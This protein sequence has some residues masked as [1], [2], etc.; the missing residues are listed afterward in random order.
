MNSSNIEYM[1]EFLFKYSDEELDNLELQ[2]TSEE[3][4]TFK[5]I[6]ELEQQ[7]KDNNNKSFM[8]DLLEAAK[9]G[10]MQYL[11]SMTD[12][13]DTFMKQKR[14]DDT[15]RWDDVKIAPIN[16]SANKEE[17][18]AFKPRTMG[19]ANESALK[20]NPN[21]TDGMSESG[22]KIFKRYE[23]AY[24]QRT[25]SLTQLS[26][27]DSTIERSN[28]KVNFETLSGLRGYRIGPVVAMPSAQQ[29]K[30]GYEAYVKDNPGGKSASYW[31]YDQ[32]MK[33][34]DSRLAQ[35]L[36]FKTA[37]EAEK[38]RKEN[39]L[40]VH[41]GPDGMFMVPSDVHS[42]AR[43]NGYRSMMTEFIKGEITESEMN[44]YIRDEKIAYVSHE[45]KERGIRMVKGIGM[46]AIKDVLKCGVVVICEETYLEFKG[47]SDDKFVDRMLRILKKSWEHVKNKC[48]E[49]IKNLLANIKGS[50]L[51]EILTAINDFFLGTFKNIFKIVRQMWSSIKNAFK[52][53]FSKDKNISIGE[54][55]FEASKILTAGVVSIIG[56][57]LNELIEKA[58]TSIGIP[59]A[60]FISEC[61]AGLFAGIMSAIVMMLF[62]K[63]KHKFM[64]ES[65]YVRELQLRSKCL[66]IDS[67]LISI[68]SLRTD[69]KMLETYNFVGQ[70]FGYIADVRSHIDEQR[71]IA[72]HLT[73]DVKAKA[74]DQHRRGDA[75]NGMMNKY[76]KNDNF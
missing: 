73:E 36:G 27:G 29:A 47:K 6:L 68:D 57:S 67:A 48:S 12:T 9:D 20:L 75:L 52:I 19:Q 7:I 44:K 28:D 5:E 26:T 62:D 32:N 16:T 40:T 35:E 69:K 55:I 76:V 15:S 33:E 60:S 2:L 37:A 1:P 64:T 22:K 3:E 25:K 51:S 17:S 14:S 56:F 58:L 13:N 21:V 61:L 50:V 66:L 11:D 8:K 45:A 74:S 54:R 10:T 41:E 46:S 34:F 70:I 4:A 42:A 23:T 53:I 39:K 63:F 38:W 24:S 43:H 59:F 72:V 49:I 18:S 30:E 65:P 71:T 31:L